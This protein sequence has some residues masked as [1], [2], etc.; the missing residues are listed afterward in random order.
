MDP[1]AKNLAA[2]VALIPAPFKLNLEGMGGKFAQQPCQ[3]TLT[4]LGAAALVFYQAEKGS[5][6][7]VN[8]IFDA[9]EYCASSL[10]VGYTN[11]YPRT[12]LGKLVATLLMTFGPAMASSILKGPPAADPTPSKMLATLEEILHV[13]RKSGADAPV[14]A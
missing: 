14:G 2:L 1:I 11:I 13:L 7:K 12:P 10:S 8:T 9:L 3:N 4:A 5:N 6:P